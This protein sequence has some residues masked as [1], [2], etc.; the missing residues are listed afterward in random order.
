MLDNN[1]YFK[2]E[3]TIKRPVGN[4]ILY[5]PLSSCSNIVCL[6]STALALNCDNTKV[7]YEVHVQIE[8]TIA[9]GMFSFCSNE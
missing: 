6:Q 5:H 3:H 2:I 9:Q 1:Q 4:Y 7:L 8:F